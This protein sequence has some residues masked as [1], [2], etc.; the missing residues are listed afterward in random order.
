MHGKNI[1]IHDLQLLSVFLNKKRANKRFA[2]AKIVVWIYIF[3]GFC[4]K[5]QTIIAGREWWR[6]NKGKDPLLRP[7]NRVVRF[8]IILSTFAMLWQT[9]S[10]IAITKQTAAHPVIHKNRPPGHTLSHAHNTHKKQ[11]AQQH[12]KKRPLHRT[13]RGTFARHIVHNSNTPPPVLRAMHTLPTPVLSIKR[14]GNHTLAL[15]NMLHPDPAKIHATPVN[16]P[17]ATIRPFYGTSLVD[18]VDK[19]VD[20]LHYNSYSLGGGRFDAASGVYILDCSRFIDNIL[21]RMYPDAL[22]SLVHASGAQQPATIHY[23]D[24]FTDLYQGFSSR[25]WNPVEKIRQLRPGDILVFR[26]KKPQ[27]G[28][29]GG[30]IMIVMDRPV[31]TSHAFSVRVADSAPIRHSEDTRLLHESGIGIGTLLLKANPATGKP[32]AYAWERGGSWRRNVKFAMA[33]PIRLDV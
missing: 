29:A 8:F 11:T 24:F 2:R 18:F 10:A 31:K 20:T 13:A 22:H 1:T 30:H 21:D 28:R 4:S 15:V 5:I 26:F 12:N 17:Q 6:K 3:C 19:T 16:T 25:Y 7:Q 32:A 14:P 27:R 23:Y 9:P 33:R